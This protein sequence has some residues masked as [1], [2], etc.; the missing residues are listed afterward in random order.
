M[1]CRQGLACREGMF[2]SISRC[3]L[4]LQ[5]FPCTVCDTSY[6]RDQP[7]YVTPDAPSDK[8]SARGRVF[9]GPVRPVGCASVDKCP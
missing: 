6:G 5:H 9:T 1:P 2:R 8:V 7:C 3:D 4:L